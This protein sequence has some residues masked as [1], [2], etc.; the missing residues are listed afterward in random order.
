MICLTTYHRGAAIT[1]S[2]Q[3]CTNPGTLTERVDQ[4]NALGC[5]VMLAC[6]LQSSRA[7]T[8]TITWQSTNSGH[9][10]IPFAVLPFRIPAKGAG[11]LWMAK[12]IGI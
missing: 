3:Q 8:G 12:R 6:A 11:R 2:N 10:T 9:I 1:V 4:T 7:D 5:S